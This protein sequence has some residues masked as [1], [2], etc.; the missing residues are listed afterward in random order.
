MARQAKVLTAKELEA[1]ANKVGEHNAGGVSGTLLLVVRETAAGNV[2]RAWKFR[3]RKNG[4]V[5]SYG[6]GTYTA[7]RKDG[8]LTVEQ[9]RAEARRILDEVR[10]GRDPRK[11]IPLDAGTALPKTIGVLFAEFF[12]HC[13]TQDPPR[14]KSKQPLRDYRRLYDVHISAA[15]DDLTPNQITPA[16]V[17]AVVTPVMKKCVSSGD[18]VKGLL[19]M[20][21]KWCLQTEQ[22]YRD[23]AL[24]NPA[25]A[26]MLEGYLPKEEH[27]A[28]AK[29]LAACPLLDLP[30]FVKMA[31]SDGRLNHA[32]TL[33]LL[34]TLLT[35]SRQGNVVK[36]KQMNK[37]TYAEWKDIDLSQKGR[38]M[39]TIPPQKMKVAKNGEHL[40]PLSREAVMILRRLQI[41]GM[42][43]GEAVF[44]SYNGVVGLEAG[45]ALIRK[46]SAIDK[47]S[48]GNGF[49]DPKC[50]HVM[51][52]HGTARACF[53]TWAAQ[54]EDADPYM[55][56][57][58]LHHTADRLG[59][60]YMRT[61]VAEKRRPLMQAW[62]DFLFSECPKD[63]AEVKP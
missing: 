9:A 36:N 35:C 4:K 48:G 11:V 24:G 60:A 6:L 54:Q 3:T 58:A 63:W 1:L 21:F 15:F 25:S 34:F 56:Q 45:P 61:K 18:K 16:R 31:V 2:S 41:L 38:E 33:A 62:A 10:N 5:S 8:A 30:R 57:T 55:I 14:W 27:C 20:F 7:R 22:G 43:D 44:T 50:G 19:S 12:R 13:E 53:Q 46:L 39:W 51:T 47:A 29:H 59:G 23:L 42:V 40:V 26:L 32:G 28:P 17:A 37:V 52:M 49:I